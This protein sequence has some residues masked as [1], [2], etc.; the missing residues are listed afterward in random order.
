MKKQ[1]ITDALI[2]AEENKI[3]MENEVIDHGDQ[4]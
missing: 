1:F 2:E 3:L 4:L